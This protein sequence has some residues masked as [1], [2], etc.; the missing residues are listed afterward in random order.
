M[1]DIIV[2]DNF[3]EDPDILRKNIFNSYK[4]QTNYRVDYDN[5]HF[6]DFK[7]QYDELPGLVKK[8]NNLFDPTFETTSFYNDFHKKI[9]EKLLDSKIQ[10][11]CE[12]N[13]IF[14]LNSCISNPVSININ[15]IK[16]SVNIEEWV[17]IIFLTPDAPLEGGITIYNHKKMNKNSI[18]SFRKMEK[19]IS[20]L[21]LVE[22]N[23][24]SKDTTFWEI[25]TQIANVYN[26]L[27]LLKKDLFYKSS[28]N[29]GINIEDSRLTQFFSFGVSM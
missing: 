12:K 29:Y 4:I 19:P 10:Y 6:I 21:I 14:I 23:N 13:G 9:F 8:S 5:L 28:L 18:K 11:T 7:G 15:D 27:I 3:Y 24:C 17:G 25:D 26:R 20:D 2:Y 16:E 1:K 22:L